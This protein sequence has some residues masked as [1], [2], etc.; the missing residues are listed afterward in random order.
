MQVMLH[1]KAL[2][3]QSGGHWVTSLTWFLAPVWHELDMNATSHSGLGT[4]R[5][6]ADRCKPAWH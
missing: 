5:W 3:K 1:L 6:S 4:L 2:L